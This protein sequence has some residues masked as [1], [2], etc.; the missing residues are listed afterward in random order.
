MNVV[1]GNLIMTCM[2]LRTYIFRTN[3]SRVTNKGIVGNEITCI[4][5]FHT[6]RYVVNRL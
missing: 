2:Y 6:F 1:K 4:V 5:L 3:D